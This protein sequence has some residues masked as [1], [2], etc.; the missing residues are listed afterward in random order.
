MGICQCHR[1]FQRRRCNSPSLSQWPRVNSYPTKGP[2]TTT[3]TAVSVEESS[4]PLRN[5]S[6]SSRVL[7]RTTAT[8]STP[9]TAC[10]TESSPSED[11]PYSINDAIGYTHTAATLPSAMAT[12]QNL[13]AGTQ[14]AC[15][16]RTPIQPPFLHYQLPSSFPATFGATNAVISQGLTD[17][18]IQAIFV[19]DPRDRHPQIC[20]VDKMVG[21]STAECASCTRIQMLPGVLHVRVCGL[22][23]P[24]G[25]RAAIER[26]F[27]LCAHPDCL[28]RKP[29]FSN[30]RV[31]PKEIKLSVNSFLDENHIA[32]LTERRLPLSFPVQDLF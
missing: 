10:P 26:N 29:P 16:S 12:S 8:N 17:A 21:R 11:F 18:E 32:I 20:Y 15:V 3:T 23:I 22:W 24:R 5:A 30:L 14:H 2:N 19:S 25:R 28:L 6:F 7:P 4:R 27:Y 13:Y 1:A 31:P 9:V